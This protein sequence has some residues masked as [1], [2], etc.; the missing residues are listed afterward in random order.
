L[1]EGYARR[2]IQKTARVDA[3][4]RLLKL[5]GAGI[6]VMALLEPTGTH[7]VLAQE[8]SSLVKEI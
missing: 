8:G 2:K 3:S 4:A 5:G 7:S 6:A 1:K